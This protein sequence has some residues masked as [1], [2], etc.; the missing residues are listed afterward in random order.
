MKFNE[1]RDIGIKITQYES[2][3]KCISIIRNY[4]NESMGVIKSEIESNDFV[5]VCDFTDTPNLKIMLK[6]HDK[7]AKLGCSLTIQE[8][9]RMIPRE[10]LLNLLQ[11]HK[12]I[13]EETLAAIDAEV[14]DD[15]DDDI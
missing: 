13:H 11:M 5:F 15:E 10:I 8:Q 2:L 6:C 7:L 12:E 9:R 14:G 1:E 3:S 4:R